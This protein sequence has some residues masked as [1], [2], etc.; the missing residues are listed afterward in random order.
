M[1]ITGI[2]NDKTVKICKNLQVNQ[3]ETDRYN[4]F[5]YSKGIQNLQSEEFYK[6][7]F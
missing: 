2:Q 6:Q 7:M 3:T 5:I 4:Y 1:L